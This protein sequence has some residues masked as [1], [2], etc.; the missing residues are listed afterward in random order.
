MHKH[1]H[2][3]THT[4]CIYIKFDKIHIHLFPSMCTHTRTHTHGHTHTAGP[5]LYWDL[6]TCKLTCMSPVPGLP[7]GPDPQ[8]A[9]QQVD[10]EADQPSLPCLWQRPVRRAAAHAA[11]D[12][13]PIT[14]WWD[15]LSS[16]ARRLPT[17]WLHRR[18]RGTVFVTLQWYVKMMLNQ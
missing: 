11:P 15:G 17:V 13:P 2:T 8:P 1:T 12:H 18:P 6:N 5:F 16:A 4:D 3:H 10:G 7:V 14:Q 9:Q